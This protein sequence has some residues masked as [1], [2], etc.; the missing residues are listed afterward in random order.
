MDK[1]R[2]IELWNEQLAG[3]ISPE[4]EQLLTAYLQQNPSVQV[5]F[6]EV[7]QTW[8]M[9]GEL[10]T[11]EPSPQ[12]DARFHA[13][14]ASQKASVKESS[15][16]MEIL[17]AWFARSWQMGLASLII[18]LLI[19][20]QML[21]SNQQNKEVASLTSEIQDMKKMMMLT[22][23]EQPKAQDRIQAVNMVS[24]LS[25]NDEKVIEAL[26]TTLNTDDNLNVRLAAVESLAGLGNVPQAREAL[27]MAIRQQESP[28]IQVAIADA[29]VLIQAKNSVEELEALRE[30][31]EDDLV[32]DK[33]EQS[34]KTLKS[35]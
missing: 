9:L 11:P 30:T 19:G 34:I 32:K 5:E 1:E 2:A 24:N 25:S 8:N 7:T 35:I 16:P 23:I 31:V 33:L 18:G 15:N 22:L 13:M 28:I 17:V 14:M 3:E 27:V 29:L 21:P 6:D 4:N 26:I 12:M 20:W 10:P